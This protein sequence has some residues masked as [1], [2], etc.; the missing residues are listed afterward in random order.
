M[1]AQGNHQ[2]SSTFFDTFADSASTRSINI[3]LSIAAAENYEMASIDVKTAFLYSPIRETVYLK[4][5]PGLSPNIMLTV[6]KL[7]K[8][9]YGLRQAAH[10]W[11]NLLDKSVKTLGFTQFKTDA[12]IIS[13]NQSTMFPIPYDLVYQL[14][15]FYVLVNRWTLLTGFVSNEQVNFQ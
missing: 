7:N 15:I 2:D 9:L 6:V 10:E 12:S 11:R 3:L 1:V 14:M 13:P 5:P 4:R 8:C